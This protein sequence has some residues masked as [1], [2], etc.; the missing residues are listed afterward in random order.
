[1]EKYKNLTIKET[2]ALDCAIVE[3]RR[4]GDKRGFFESVTTDE[5]SHLGF[6]NFNQFSDSMSGKG[7]LRGLHYQ[8][9]PY[10]QAKMVRCVRGKVVDIV[11]DIRKDSPTF[12]ECVAV[13][14]TPD[15]GRFL[16]VPRGFAHAYLA[17][18]DNSLFE[19]YVDNEYNTRKEGGIS[20]KDPNMVVNLYE[21]GPEDEDYKV[22]KLSIY[23]LLKKYGIKK[24]L[25]SD[26]DEVRKTLEETDVN[27]TREKKKYL[28]TGFR[29]QLGYDIVRELKARGESDILALDIQEMDITDKKA[30]MNIIEAYKP[31][32]IFH[33]A[34]WTQVDKAEENRELC[35]KV[36]VEGTK[37]MVDASIKVGAKIVYVSTDYVFDGTKEG[38]YTEEDKPNPQS[39]YGLTKYQGEEEVRRNPNHFIARISWAFGINGNNFIKTMIKLSDKNKEVNVVD[40]QIGSPT[41]T[42]DLSKLLVEMAHTDKYGTYNATNT[43]YCTWADFAEEIFKEYGA[44]VKVN[45]VTIDEYYKDKMHATRPENSKFSWDKL[46]ENGFK[47]MPEWQDALKRYLNEFNESTEG[48]LLKLKRGN[49]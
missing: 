33:C 43:G 20:Y 21:K 6:T 48:K 27:F 15:N 5:L 34:A 32:I 42:V 49:K 39:V 44:D 8:E 23:D 17:V 10:C 30:V 45:H 46:E 40:D 1:M 13:E 24:P 16:F 26:K 28:V 14:L 11:R 12:G 7:I 25:I 2:N 31:D 22:V 9:D 29:G 35:E 19:Y 4:F 18:E 3:P 41:Y 36:N 38:Y 37:N 47:K